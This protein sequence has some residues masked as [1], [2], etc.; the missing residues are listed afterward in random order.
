[1]KSY[2]INEI[3]RMDLDCPAC[4]SAGRNGKLVPM[5]KSPGLRCDTKNNRFVNKRWTVCSFCVWLKPVDDRPT[6]YTLRPTEFPKIET[7]THEQLPIRNWFGTA[8]SLK[9]GR[10]LIINAGPGCGKTSTVSWAAEAAW[11]R[12]GDLNLFE[13]VAFNRNAKDVLLEKLPYQVTGIFTMNGLGMRMQNYTYKNVDE[14]K[15]ERLFN[16]L[17]KDIHP[18]D[19]PPI[20]GITEIIEKMRAFGMYADPEQISW[21][22]QA[23]ICTATRFGM[24]ERVKNEEETIERWLKYVPIMSKMALENSKDI[25]LTEQW[26]FAVTET[27]AR[28]GISLSPEAISRDFE[29]DD[30]FIAQLAE[31]CR[32][33]QLPKPKGLVIDEGQDLSLG[34]ILFFV[35]SAWKNSELIVIGDDKNHDSGQ[36]RY[37]AG[38]GIY[39]W[40]GSFGGSMALIG[41]L[42]KELTGEKATELPLS[43]TFRSSPEV[44]RSINRLNTTLKSAKKEGS[45]FA[46]AADMQTAFSLWCGMPEEMGGKKLT[47]FWITRTNKAAGEVF[48]K[49]IKARTP[50]AFRGGNGFEKSLGY[51]LY[52]AT[53]D[54]DKPKDRVAFDFK[55]G[56]YPGVSIIDARNRLDKKVQEVA[57]ES[58]EKA[59][60][61]LEQ[62]IV[63]VID[64]LLSDP[65]ILEQVSGLPHTEVTLGNVRR[66]LLAFADKNSTRVI[67]NVYRVKGEESEWVF[68]SDSDQFNK[69]WNQDADEA[70]ACRLVACSR[71]ATG[72]FVIGALA[73]VDVRPISEQDIGTVPQTEEKRTLSY[74]KETFKPNFSKVKFTKVGDGEYTW[75]KFKIKKE[76]SFLYYITNTKTQSVAGPFKDLDRCRKYLDKA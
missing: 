34:Q 33:I 24:F 72:L 69:A 52:G 75:D 38:Q 4:T 59:A 32:E 56:E 53:A 2:T 20:D 61:M 9:G 65:T 16:E 74:K 19:R 13:F 51:I 37:K 71:A 18:D 73:G 8:P 67:S 30:E 55:S 45:G 50:V 60:D 58:E 64:E 26:S 12:F 44:V 10:L 54:E 46:Y 66:F 41:R 40:R 17:V 39:G 7:P 28:T 47:A 68:V 23:I 27:L 3:G 36:E 31:I 25:D 5:F 6:E 29:M 1:M 49:S 76:S 70:A 22:R 43:I 63:S 15:L 57:V 35:G 62:F 21:W 11:K 14:H 42:W 48:M